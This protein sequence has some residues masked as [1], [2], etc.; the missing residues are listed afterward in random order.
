MRQLHRVDGLEATPEG[1][2]LRIISQNGPLEVNH[3]HVLVAAPLEQSRALLD[4]AGI[5]VEGRSE[6]CWVAWGPAPDQ[7]SNR[8]P[9][10][11]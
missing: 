7:D 2:R 8:L 11:R 9:A 3:D 6:A 5:H 1:A 4:T 10:G